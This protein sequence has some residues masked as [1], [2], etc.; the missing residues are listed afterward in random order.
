MSR[1]A[2]GLTS[3][4]RASFPKT[5]PKSRAKAALLRPSLKACSSMMYRATVDRAI[6]RDLMQAVTAP[7][8]PAFRM[9]RFVARLSLTTI[10]CSTRARTLIRLPSAL[11]TAAAVGSTSNARGSFFAALGNVFEIS[12][13]SSRVYF[14][15]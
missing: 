4:P 5:M 2:E 10:M 14:P 13:S 6:P 15:S 8:P 1:E 3:S 12:T 9:R 11:A 7:G